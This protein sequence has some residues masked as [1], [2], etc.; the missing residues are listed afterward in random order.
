MKKKSRNIVVVMV[1]WA[2]IF[3]SLPTGVKVSAASK[4]KLSKKKLTLYVNQTKKLKLKGTKK[5]VK[6]SSSNKKVATVSQKG[7]VKAKKKG[8]CKIVAKVGK[9]KYVCRVTVKNRKVKATAVPKKPVYSKA[10]VT[11]KAPS[12][13]K[14]PDGSGTQNTSVS[15]QEISLKDDRICVTFTGSI[16]LSAE[17]FAVEAISLTSQNAL[18][19]ELSVEKISR[20]TEKKVYQ[21]TVTN[22]L[23]DL[24]RFRVTVNSSL[25][26]GEKSIISDAYY[27]EFCVEKA[28]YAGTAVFLPMGEPM[29]EQYQVEVSNTH[30]TEDTVEQCVTASG[31]PA[32]IG[33]LYEYD[34]EDR[35]SYIGIGGTCQETEEKTGTIVI[36]VQDAV[37]ERS[38][39]VEIAYQICDTGKITV[40][41]ST[42]ATVCGK[43]IVSY[44]LTIWNG[45]EGKFGSYEFQTVSVTRDGE[46][47]EGSSAIDR[48]QFR[49]SSEESCWFIMDEINQLE[50]GNYHFI[51]SCI[52]PIEG[53]EAADI[54][55]DLVV[56][57]VVTVSVTAKAA[58]GVALNKER[59]EGLRFYTEDAKEYYQV[60]RNW[61]E[62]EEKY[63]VKLPEGT[64]QLKILPYMGMHDIGS[65]YLNSAANLGMQVKIAK[66]T[67]ALDLELATL[68]KVKLSDMV[69]DKDLEQMLAIYLG[70]D[71]TELDNTET[72]GDV[73][74]G[75]GDEITYEEFYLPEG[76]Y[77]ITGAGQNYITSLVSKCSVEKDGVVNIQK[78]QRSWDGLHYYVTADGKAEVVGCDENVT[79][80][81]L[82][83]KVGG[84]PVSGYF[85]EPLQGCSKLEYLT[86]EDNVDFR[87][88]GLTACTALKNIVLPEEMPEELEENLT[89]GLAGIP[90]VE[91]ISFSG[92]NANYRIYDNAIYRR[93]TESLVYCPAGKTTIRFMEGLKTI[94]ASAMAN[95]QIQ[96]IRIPDTV[97]EIG[98]FAFENSK[99]QEVILPNNAAFTTIEVYLFF[100]CEDLKCITVPDSVTTIGDFAFGNCTNIEEIV[101]PAGLQKIGFQGLYGMKGKI[102]YMGTIRQWENIDIEDQALSG[103]TIY[104]S[105]GEY[106]MPE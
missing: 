31:M 99:V 88:L 22:G 77:K 41:G 72:F 97:Q 69:G 57:E 102:T 35:L 59:I 101:F 18:P 19:Q 14:A 61:D 10:P 52:S 43:N 11:T 82:S 4:V 20:D 1:L 94:E 42:E 47:I 24:S 9:K 39:E 54:E 90:N 73:Y 2:L 96:E 13:T 81:S 56:Q 30:I 44:P 49:Y 105:D 58:D 92:D 98:D 28:D 84:Y 60:Y 3:A 12:V 25:I 64:Y 37:T 53:I 63:Q 27:K 29:E 104:C 67:D 5:K 32:G 65:I 34:R 87:D 33:L 78:P 75:S 23:P 17:D 93:G 103:C 50:S 83:N 55:L 8:K 80:L 76:N 89:W 79:I 40:F 21:L 46:E 91:N 15:L 7:K 66:D 38:G 85:Y 62:A 70:L 74:L 48:I 16:R 68:H 51:I 26:S 71:N 6:W 86:I 100:G 106:T 36:R 95:S 45:R